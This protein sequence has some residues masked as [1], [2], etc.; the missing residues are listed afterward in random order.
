MRIA[1]LADVHLGCRIYERLTAQG[2]NIREQDIAQAFG[3]AIDGVIAARVDLVLLAG[4]FFH[5]VRPTNSAILVAYRELARLRQSL[6]NTPVIVI[7]GDHDTPRSS[8][9]TPILSL[10]QALGVDVV[11]TG[12]VRLERAGAVVTCVP[13]GALAQLA[14]VAPVPGKLNILL[15]H[16]EARDLPHQARTIAADVL[17]AAW[18]YVAL[19]HYHVHQ[20]VAPRAW[21]AGSLDYVSTDPWKDLREE[22]RAGL[23]GKGWLC[24]ELP[25][26]VP[27]LERIAPPRVFRDLP[28]LSGERLNPAE[29]SAAILERV[30][31]VP[32]GAVARLV[33]HDVPRAVAKELAWDR[34]RAEKG[35]LTIL[36]LDLRRP[37]VEAGVERRRQLFQNLDEVVFGFLGDRAA[38]LQTQ[39][40]SADEAAEFQRLGND[41]FAATAHRPSVGTGVAA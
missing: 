7:S 22:A 28:S 21:Y 23:G 26:G 35:R 2:A 31:E 3:R 32:D 30:A 18:D 5:A 17:A 36:H 12:V 6:P 1:H 34:I 41:Y 40:W 24:C 4:D 15:A 14:D 11:Q 16:G 10:Y 29:L 20:Q 33:V 19:G 27:T 37:E 13:Q 8:T 25:A 9:T 39:G 38:Q